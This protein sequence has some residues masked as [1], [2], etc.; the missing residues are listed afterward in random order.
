[1][2]SGR[3]MN[4]KVI[5]ENQ[6]HCW[7]F[8]KPRTMQLHTVCTISFFSHISAHFLIGRHVVGT[9]TKK[10]KKKPAAAANSGTHSDVQIL[11][12]D[13]Y[14]GMRLGIMQIS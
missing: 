9:D 1:M 7:Y 3:E 13:L 5:N 8:I 14:C 10:G 4:M 11:C 6:A 2:Y 12:D